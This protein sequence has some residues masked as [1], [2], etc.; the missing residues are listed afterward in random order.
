MAS[1]QTVQTNEDTEL[2]INLSANDL[3][4]DTLTYTVLSDPTHGELSGEVPNLTYSPQTNF[5]DTD[6]FTFKVNDGNVD[7]STAIVTINVLPVNDTPELTV[8]VDQTTQAGVPISL[9]VVVNDIDSLVTELTVTMTS[10][11]TT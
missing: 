10:S 1:A 7:S 4:D 2:T 8:I 3:E 11:N 6:S 9:S 5:N